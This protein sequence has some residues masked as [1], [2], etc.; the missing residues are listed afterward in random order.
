MNKTWSLAQDRK[1]KCS[2]PTLNAGVPPPRYFLANHTFSVRP[3]P[4][5]LKYN[6]AAGTKSRTDYRYRGVL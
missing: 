5:F 3:P 6:D 2:R 4:M 1:K